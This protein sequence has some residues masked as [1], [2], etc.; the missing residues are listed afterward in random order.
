MWI[1]LKGPLLLLLVMLSKSVISET[2]Y[3]YTY[4]EEAPGTVIAVLSN[5]SVFNFTESSV[6]NFRLKQFNTTVIHV[7]ESDGQLSIGERIDREQLCKQSVPCILSLDVVSFSKERLTLIHILVEVK[8]INDNSPHFPSTEINVE[9]SESAP[10]GTRISLGIAVDEDVG[11]NSI[12]SFQISDNSLFSLVVQTRTDG[13]KYADLVLMKELDREAQPSYTLELVASDGGSPSRSASAVVNV[14]VLDFN[15]N[16]PVF[17]KSTFT[18]DLMEDSPVGQLFL[19][20]NAFDSDEGMNGEVV[21]GFSPQVSTEVRQLFKIDPK[22]GG[23]TLEGHVDFETKQTYEFDVQA[24]DLGPNPLT[25]TCK[26]TVKIVDVNDNA[27]VITITPLT[28]ISAGVPYITESAPRDSFVALIS[29][30]DRD[31]GPNGQVHCTLYGHEHFKL[32]QAYEDSFMIVTTSALDRERIAEYNLTIVA[33]D[34]GFPSLKTYKT[35]TIRVSDENDNAPIFVKS[36]NDV[37]VMESNAPGAYITTV[38]ARDPDLGHNG[39]VTYS[40]VDTK[41]MGQTLSTYVALD[42]VSGVLRAVRSFDYEKI[43]QIDLEIQATDNGIPELSTRTQMKINIIDQNDNPPV[44]TYPFLTNGSAEI[45]LPIRAPESYLIFQIKA[46]DADE[47]LNSHLFYTITR[48]NHRLFSINRETGEVFLR[49]QIHSLEVQ[50][51]SIDVAVYDSGRPSLFCSAAIKFTLTDTT[52]ASID[53]VVM[54]PS[55]KEQHQIDLTFIFIAVLAGGCCL[56][57]TAII[58]VACTWKRKPY[59]I[60]SEATNKKIYRED[61]LLNNAAPPKSASSSNSVTQS[62]SFQISISTESEDCSEINPS[63]HTSSFHG[64]ISVPSEHTSSWHEEKSVRSE[65]GHS[66]LER[67]SAKDS[68]RGDSDFN[69]S[70]SDTSGEALKKH[71]QDTQKQAGAAHNDS[72]L[73]KRN[74]ENYCTYQTNK[75]SISGNHMLHCEKG[76][77]M[78]YPVVPTY[79]N[80]H[81][82]RVP[83]VPIPQHYLKDSYYYVHVPKTE[84]TQVEYERYLLNSV[85]T[86][87]PSRLSRRYEEKHNPDISLHPNSSEIATA[88]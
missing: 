66:H 52:P 45:M 32:Q 5:H 51:L 71:Q 8:D 38:I 74:A 19:D 22:F 46:S 10:V 9:V 73:A 59:Q 83:N 84:R 23:V 34:L 33:E 60:K 86:F 50:D 16:S 28:S 68:G 26:I 3:F 49:R 72:Q 4:E 81:H 58:F 78:S 87:S 76:Y 62:D 57:L 48:D 75:T 1:I 88:F 43:K 20:L 63:T 42:S 35:H 30:T 79:Y 41:V 36:L 64:S 18:I 17:E 21:Y 82:P 47:G 31:S 37:A 80:T 24:Q 54:E 77:T 27:P 53:I 67:L 2:L 44:I 56:L 12:Q 70:D 61:K 55:A 6:T 11:S 13:V 25:A 65:S 7:R 39:K 29:I 40:L 85:G 14:R 69:D 15:D